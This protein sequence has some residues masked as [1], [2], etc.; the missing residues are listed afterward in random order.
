[1]TGSICTGY[2]ASD[3]VKKILFQKKF[4]Q[5]NQVYFAPKKTHIIFHKKK[6]N[7]NN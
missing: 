4:K 3:K 2:S 5:H 1:M 7:M 6:Q